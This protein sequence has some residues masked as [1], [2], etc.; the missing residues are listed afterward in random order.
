MWL[1]GASRA[2]GMSDVVIKIDYSM[3]N[4]KGSEGDAN[5]M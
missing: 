2:A 3:K 4:A 5:R 1:A